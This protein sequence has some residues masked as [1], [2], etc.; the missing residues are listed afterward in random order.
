M[1]EGREGREREKKERRSWAASGGKGTL[2][3]LFVF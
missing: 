2:E 3:F 1:G